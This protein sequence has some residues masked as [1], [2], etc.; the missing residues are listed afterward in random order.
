MLLGGSTGFLKN[1]PALRQSGSPGTISIPLARANLA[2]AS[3][4]SA[5]LAC[6]VPAKCRFKSAYSNVGRAAGSKRIG[7]AQ[8]DEPS[9]LAG[10]EDA[11]TIGEAAGLA[12]QFANLII[13]EIEDLDRLDRLGNLLP[14]GA[15]VLHRRAAHAARDPAQALD[16]GAVGQDGVRD[17]AIP[18]FAC[19]D[20]EQNLVLVNARMLLD[21]RI[22]I[23]RT[24]PG[25]PESETTRSLPPPRTKS[26]RFRDC[27][28]ATASC[29]SA[30]DF[31]STKNRAGPPSRKV[32]SGASETFSSSCMGV[33]FNIQRRSAP[34]ILAAGWET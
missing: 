7:H 23:L 33:A 30:V 17:E 15:D 34:A 12:T 32:V 28:N 25:H 8:N 26:G 31:A 14:I 11:R 27:A 1:D 10:V 19:A 5:T 22:A 24:S 13:F 29:T 9:A 20:I 18:G 2:T 4:V 3:R 21:A 16:A 6:L